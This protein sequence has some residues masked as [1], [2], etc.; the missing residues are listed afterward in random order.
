[1]YVC[2]YTQ[3]IIV[4]QHSAF[5]LRH[6]NKALAVEL[7]SRKRRISDLESTLQKVNS[8]NTFLSA[9][10]SAI[11]RSWHMLNTD[12]RAAMTSLLGDD[13]KDLIGNEKL[14]LEEVMSAVGKNL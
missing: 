4:E 14:L 13:N 2:I 10:H 12:L 7:R 1:M 3:R 8:R 11:G 9:S 6:Q 5:Y